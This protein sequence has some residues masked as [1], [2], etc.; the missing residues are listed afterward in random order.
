MERPAASGAGAFIRLPCLGRI[1]V[2]RGRGV[3]RHRREAAGL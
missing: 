2:R 1:A 3:G